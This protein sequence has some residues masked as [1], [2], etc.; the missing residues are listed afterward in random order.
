MTRS[1]RV[2][3]TEYIKIASRVL[4]SLG[5]GV[6]CDCCGASETAVVLLMYAWALLTLNSYR[7]PPIFVKTLG[8][9]QIISKWNC[10][11]F[12]LSQCKLPLVIPMARGA[13]PYR[14]LCC[15]LSAVL[16]LLLV[17]SP[18]ACSLVEASY[19]RHSF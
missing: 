4:S 19:L 11:L 14:Q 16:L 6:L 18:R 7:P 9:T 10:L 8:L 3:R 5:G 17:T 2:Y 1:K 12:F 13:A 15:S